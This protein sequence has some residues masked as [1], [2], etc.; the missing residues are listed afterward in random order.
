MRLRRGEGSAMCVGPE[1]CLLKPET[2]NLVLLLCLSPFFSI[3]TMYLLAFLL[4]FNLLIL[5]KTADARGKFLLWLFWLL[6]IM[7][8]CAIF[9]ATASRTH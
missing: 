7:N 3:V 5:Y 4:R 2:M 6:G 8:Y 1:P 9:I